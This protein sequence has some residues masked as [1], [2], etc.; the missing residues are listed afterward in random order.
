MM[1][2]DRYLKW[3]GQ[4]FA[5]PVAACTQNEFVY[6][7]GASTTSNFGVGKVAVLE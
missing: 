7:P 5:E 3:A 1:L 4:G 2:G 6:F